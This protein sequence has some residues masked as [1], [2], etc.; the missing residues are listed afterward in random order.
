VIGALLLE[1]RDIPALPGAACRGR[2]RLFDRTIAAS[3]TGETK[4]T[5]KAR[6]AARRVC[7][8]CPELETCWAWVE[9]L[10]L[11]HRPKGIVGGTLIDSSGRCPATEARKRQHAR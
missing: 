4:A 3:T 8:E 9:S 1:L 2:E 6:R 10:P 7:A 5:T 11:S